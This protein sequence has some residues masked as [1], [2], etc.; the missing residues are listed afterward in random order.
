V[1]AF[2]ILIQRQAGQLRGQLEHAQARLEQLEQEAS[3]S[4]RVLAVLTSRD[5]RMIRLATSAPE[6]PAFRAYW[7]RPE[8][9]VLVGSNIPAPASGRAMQLWVVPKQGVPISAGVFTPSAHGMVLHIAQTVAAPGDAAALAISD[10]PAGG[11]PQPTTK[12]NWV[13]PLAD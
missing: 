6:A 9:L 1:L 11:S 3:V 2:A 4:R 5:A 10:E 12:P 13:G 8:G 7:S